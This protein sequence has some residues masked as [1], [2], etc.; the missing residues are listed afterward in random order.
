MLLYPYWLM[1][2]KSY[3]MHCTSY[4]MLIDMIIELEYDLMQCSTLLGDYQ[5]YQLS[6][7]ITCELLCSLHVLQ[8]HIQNSHSYYCCPRKLSTVATSEVEYSSFIV[9]TIILWTNSICIPWCH[10]HT[11]SLHITSHIQNPRE[12]TPTSGREQKPPNILLSWIF[13]YFSLRKN[14][15]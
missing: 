12:S 10:S 5:P 11:I 7:C 13:L 1:I 8:M 3:W 4:S 2:V 6:C 9:L 14:V 15:I